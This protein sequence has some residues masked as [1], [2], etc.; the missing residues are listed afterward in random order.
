MIDNGKIILAD[1]RG[2][3]NS[4]DSNNSNSS[5]SNNSN[6]KSNSKSNS[7]SGVTFSLM[8]AIHPDTGT[9]GIPP[10][11]VCLDNNNCMFRMETSNVVDSVDVLESNVTKLQLPEANSLSESSQEQQLQT[12]NFKNDFNNNTMGTLEMETSELDK[13]HNTGSFDFLLDWSRM[14]TSNVVYTWFNDDVEFFHLSD[15]GNDGSMGFNIDVRS[16][17][18]RN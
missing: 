1:P 6:R 14:E 2:Q 13:C 11:A 9:S 16:V 18:P 12:V 8:A 3:D 17:A 7:Q 4:H 5:N 15:R 10:V